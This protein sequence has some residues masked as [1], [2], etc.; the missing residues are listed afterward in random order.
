M[1]DDLAQST[2]VQRGER[3]RRH[4]VTAHFTNMEYVLLVGA[5]HLAG[6]S[7]AQLVTTQTVRYLTTH[8][9]AWP[10]FERAAKEM[11]ATAVNADLRRSDGTIRPEMQS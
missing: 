11:S 3:R 2:R 9:K 6:V 10:A 7:V 8:Q 4:G 5:A 1:S